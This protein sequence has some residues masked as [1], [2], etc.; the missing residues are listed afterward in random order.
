MN[1]FI[2]TIL[3]LS[4]VACSPVSSESSHVD[5]Q[6][7]A[8][9]KLVGT[10]LG[11]LILH[12][13]GS[14]SGGNR[15][16]AFCTELTSTMSK[17][18]LLIESRLAFAAWAAHSEQ[19]KA[20]FR[21]WKFYVSENCAQ[22][23][24]NTYGL[25][26]FAP[27]NHERL[28][29][30]KIRCEKQQYNMTR[31]S[32]TFLAGTGGIANFSFIPQKSGAGYVDN[33]VQ[34]KSPATITFNGNVKWRSLHEVLLGSHSLRDEYKA[35]IIND[36]KMLAY[37]S[38]SIEQY[39][40]F[41]SILENHGITPPKDPGFAAEQDKFQQSNLPAIN[42]SYTAEKAFFR[43]MLHEMGH[44]FG[45][46]HPDEPLQPGNVHGCPTTVNQDQDYTFHKGHSEHDLHSGTCSSD[47]TTKHSAMAKNH[48]LWLTDDDIAGAKSSM[49]NTEQFL[50]RG[51]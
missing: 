17:E 21:N 25:V 34:L 35:K 39:I 24:P 7:L 40:E 28:K 11:N 42:K 45:V 32:G 47:W 36:Y 50:G 38:A 26:I 48:I 31:C 49:T 29:P 37:E 12:K 20:S 4:L 27:K 5:F 14:G 9:R 13:R 51:N 19:L 30:A 3:L 18:E 44:V 16:L 46:G 8:P 6:H 15:E 23:H 33:S 2:N 1:I 22:Y 43:T 10:P 41:L